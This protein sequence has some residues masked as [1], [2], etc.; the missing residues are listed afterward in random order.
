M[1]S[2]YVSGI[3]VIFQLVVLHVILMMLIIMY[4]VYFLF[5]YESV[6]VLFYVNWNGMMEW[7]GLFDPCH[8]ALW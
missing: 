7:S 2:Q 3:Y 4:I 6:L 5:L 8:Y 1:Y